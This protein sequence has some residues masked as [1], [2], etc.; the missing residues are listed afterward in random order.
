M[1]GLMSGLLHSVKSIGMPFF[2]TGLLIKVE[3][4]FDIGILQV[5]QY[6]YLRIRELMSTDSRKKARA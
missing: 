2:I 5:R 3:K 1:H 4:L 6:G